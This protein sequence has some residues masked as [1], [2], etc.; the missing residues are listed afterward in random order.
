[1]VVSKKRGASLLATREME[2]EE[3]KKRLVMVGRERLPLGRMLIKEKG[4]FIWPPARGKVFL[5]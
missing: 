3:K 4:I 1:M 2:K 5:T